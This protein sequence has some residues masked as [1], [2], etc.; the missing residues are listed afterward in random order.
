MGEC[1]SLDQFNSLIEDLELFREE[2]AV[3]VDRLL[4]QVL[5]AKDEFEAHEDGHADH[6]GDEWKERW[7]DE[8]DRDRDVSNIFGSLRDNRN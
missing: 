1:R 2:L 5:Q 3:N 4:E 7:R 6:M 8:R